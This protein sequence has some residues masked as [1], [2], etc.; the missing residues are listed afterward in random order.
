VI[1]RDRLAAR[2]LAPSLSDARWDTYLAQRRGWE[3]F[4]PSDPHVVVDTGGTRASARADAI[5]L[6]WPWR[7]RRRLD[8]PSTP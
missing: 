1:V 3:R 5:R 8:G 7:Q 6:L 2:D 4:V